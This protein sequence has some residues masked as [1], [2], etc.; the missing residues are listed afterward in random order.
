MGLFDYVHCDHPVF[1]CSD[2]HDLRDEEFQT[3]DL[4]CTMGSA[5]IGERIS[6]HDG[7]YGDTQPAPFSGSI[8]IYADCH[9]CP[10]FVQDVTFN[11]HP[12]CVEFLVEISGDVVTKITRTSASSAEQ[13]A[14]APLLEYMPNCRGPMS[15]ED[16]RKR[17]VDRK[18]FPWDPVPVVDDDVKARHRAWRERIDSYRFRC[19]QTHTDGE[20]E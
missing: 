18:F 8:Q 2:G 3:K 13:V 5:S 1:V 20:A 12:V 6:I 9:S 16:A 15:Y 11:L 19:V 4:G 17:G 10:A 7:G 14:A